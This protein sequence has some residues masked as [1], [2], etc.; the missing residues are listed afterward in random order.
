VP[1]E[2]V[3]HMMKVAQEP[4]SLDAPVGD[5]QESHLRDF[6]EDKTT[7]SPSDA[8]ISLRFRE[9]TASVLNT[10]TPREEKILKMRYGFE[11]DHTHTLEEI[12]DSLALTRERIR[13]IEGKALRSLRASTR[14]HRLR[15]FLSHR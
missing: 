9:Q 15:V 6:L 1:A 4:V 12:G 10:L 3:R 14:A 13:Q 11:D 7:P 5:D 8:A 2:K